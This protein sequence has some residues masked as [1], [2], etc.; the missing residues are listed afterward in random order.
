MIT[1]QEFNEWLASIGIEAEVDEVHGN[2]GTVKI[3]DIFETVWV[4][5]VFGDTT[6]A[7]KAWDGVDTYAA[8]VAACEREAL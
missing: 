8:K 3:K 6:Q 1:V 7:R 5:F 4:K 2:V